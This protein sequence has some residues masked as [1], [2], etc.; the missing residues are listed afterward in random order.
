MLPEAPIRRAL[1]WSRDDN[2][3]Q[4]ALNPYEG[5][6]ES[7]DYATSYVVRRDQ[8]QGYVVFGEFAGVTQRVGAFAD[9]EE[10]REA[11]QR[12]ADERAESAEA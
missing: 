5:D 11:A 2:G 7:A 6:L 1:H 8:S 9:E 12:D 3:D 10:A 4:V